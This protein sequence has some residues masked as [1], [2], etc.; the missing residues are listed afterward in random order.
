MAQEAKDTL[1]RDILRGGG[2]RGNPPMGQAEAPVTA[3]DGLPL[4]ARIGLAKQ[5]ERY[6]GLL[7]QVE[8][9]ISSAIQG[10]REHWAELKR[11]LQGVDVR[12]RVLE[13]TP[14]AWPRLRFEPPEGDLLKAPKVVGS[15]TLQYEYSPPMTVEEAMRVLKGVPGVKI[16]EEG[17]KVRI[18]MP[19]GSTVEAAPG[20]VVYLVRDPKTRSPVSLLV[21]GTLGQGDLAN[22][23]PYQLEVELPATPFYTPWHA[24]ELSGWGGFLNGW[25]RILSTSVEYGEGRWVARL[26]LGRKDFPWG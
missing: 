12:R 7:G 23:Y 11:L 17:D 2:K 10:V 13:V 8:T 24:V 21:Q 25:W 4:L 19:D 1:W 3:L 18:T 14:L 9:I 22:Y 20:E 6:S 26:T 5:D 15:D 16:A